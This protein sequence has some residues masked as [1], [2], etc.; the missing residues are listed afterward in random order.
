MQYEEFKSLVMEQM[1]SYFQGNKRIMIH[2]ITKNNGIKLDG[3][4]ILD[5]DFNIAPTIYMNY[6]F[7]KY[8]NGSSFTEVFQD[9]LDNYEQNKPLASINVSFFTDFESAKHMIVYKVIN[10][11]KNKELL[12]DVPHF[13]FLD[14]AV[15]FYCL[16]HSG[17]TG[18]ATIL[19]HNQHMKCWNTTPEKLM[20]LARE[21]TPSLLEYDLRNIESIL[22]GGTNITPS[23]MYPM[24][25]LTNTSRLNGACCMLYKDLLRQIADNI[26]SDFFI[27][28]SSIHELVL[29]PANNMSAICELSEM[30]K[31]VNLAEVSN[32][33][34]LSDHAYYYSRK[35]DCVSM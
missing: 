17:A 5:K 27:L 26:E 23:H 28:P 15:V 4:I 22:S 7:N 1:N 21:N 6:Y 32:E 8:Q 20:E 34:I 19:I 18:N 3:L 11:E 2:T 24:F 12:E 13:H 35:N 31:E 30:V 29:L 25:I 33:E 16:V 9:L 14:L 10:Y